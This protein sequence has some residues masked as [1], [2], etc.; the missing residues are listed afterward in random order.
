MDQYTYTTKD[1]LLSAFKYSFDI[2]MKTPQSRIYFQTFRPAAASASKM[3]LR[4]FPPCR[5]LQP[6]S[7]SHKYGHNPRFQIF[8]WICYD[9]VRWRIVKQPETRTLLLHFYIFFTTSYFL[10]KLCKMCLPFIS[11]YSLRIFVKKIRRWC[12][13]TY[14]FNV[15]SD[16]F[17]VCTP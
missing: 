13:K 3:Y 6:F 4:R 11:R 14:D 16:K 1:C 5:L 9:A 2:Q 12:Y 15:V 17:Y 8:I 10:L 7:P